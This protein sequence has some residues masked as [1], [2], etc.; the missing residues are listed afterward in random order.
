MHVHI[1]AR[2]VDLEVQHIRR[3]A[4]AVQHVLVRG[5]RG[6]R[7]QLVTH[8]T[9]IH[10]DVLLV[11]ARAC[12]VGNAGAAVHAQRSCLRAHRP[13]LRNELVTQHVDEPLVGAAASPLVHEPAF[14]PQRKGDFG[15]R[16]RMAAQAFDAMG[17]LGRIGL[18][19]LAARGR[20]VEELAHLDCRPHAARRR[21]QLT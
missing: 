10:V 9:P 12:G 6:V 3:L 14:M 17:K 13:A 11:A 1:D 5:A 8:E 21:R 4:A 7:K 15:L 16:Q 19:E 2:R 18:Q 20:A